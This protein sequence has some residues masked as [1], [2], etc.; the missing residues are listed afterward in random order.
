M[1]AVCCLVSI[2][3][4]ALLFSGGCASQYNAYRPPYRN[5]TQ[6]TAQPPP[7][8][9]NDIKTLNLLLETEPPGAEIYAYASMEDRKTR[10]GTSPMDL[11]ISFC[12]YD[13]VVWFKTP[14]DGVVQNGFEPAKIN[15]VFIVSTSAVRIFMECVLPHT[16]PEP[17]MV[18][19]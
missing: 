16:L 14:Q 15:S 13:G 4:I 5:N 8:D 7:E 9:Y 12:E 1:R 6:H 11:K 19:T 3:V 18:D 17:K 10:L 2:L